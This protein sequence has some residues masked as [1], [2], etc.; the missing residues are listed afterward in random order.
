[1]VTIPRAGFS[2]VETIVALVLSSVVIILVSTTFLVQNRF[3][4]SQTLY[5]GAHDNARSATERIASEIRSLMEDGFVVAGRRTLALRS[6]IV[7]GMVCD[8]QGNEVYVHFKGGVPALDTDEAAGVAVRDVTTGEWTYR[9]S[10][11]ATV[12]GGASNAAQRCA[13]RGADTTGAT[14]EFRMVTQ[15]ESLYGAPPNSGAALMLFRQSTFKI[16]DSQLDPGRLALFRQIYGGSLVEF[17]SGMD[18]SAQFQYRTGGTTYADTVIAASLDDIDAVRIVA[19]ARKRQRSG[20]QED[21]R[22]GWSVNVALRN[23][24]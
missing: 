11:W 14:A 10:T 2:L 16:Q 20:G 7:V 24:P 18:T 21:I 9:N 19:D 13:A 3:Y 8:R 1:V 4:S 6:P 23:V 17:A 5:A 15:L 22:F 12:D